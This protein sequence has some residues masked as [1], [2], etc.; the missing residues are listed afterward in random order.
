MKYLL[1]FVFFL[2]AGCNNPNNNYREATSALEA[3]RE[4]I[5][6]CLKGD[7]V[8][9]AFYMIQDEQNKNFLQK[10]EREY[11]EKDRDGRRQYREASINIAE[12]DNPTETITIINYSNTFDK[13]G[14]KIKVIQ[15]NN[16]WLVDFK[17]TFNPNL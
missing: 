8:K 1:V 6:A 2:L 11:R 16:K 4:F 13:I 7:F 14:H 15:Q 5:D 17:Y 12:I 9:A 10:I 3:G